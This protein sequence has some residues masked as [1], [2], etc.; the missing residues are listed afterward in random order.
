MKEEKNS[1]KKDRKKK[2]TQELVWKTG[3]N[4]LYPVII[5][6]IKYLQ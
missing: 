3:R 1:R 2:E 5:F 4:E 6:H